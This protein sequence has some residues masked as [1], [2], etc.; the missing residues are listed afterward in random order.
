[1][2]AA[3]YIC[4]SCQQ[5]AVRDILDCG[6]QPISNRF[7]FTANAPEVT[8]P[9]ILGQCVDCGLVQISHPVPAAELR[10][11]FD[12]I[13]YTEP[14]GHLAALVSE[15]AALPGITSASR[16]GAVVFGGD[17]TNIRFKERGFENNWRV[18]LHHDLG[19]K[20]P[21]SGTETIQERLTPAV[22]QKIVNRHGLFDLL[23]VRHMVEH[24]Q[25]VKCFLAAIQTML[26][27]GGYAVF[28]VPDCERPFDELEYSILW[29]EHVF[30]FMPATFRHCLTSAGFEVLDLQRPRY[31]LVAI[32][33]KTDLVTVAVPLPAEVLAV[34]CSR[35]RKFARELPFRRA[36]VVKMLQACGKVAFF[37]AGH[38]GCMYIN[39][40]GLKS[41][42]AFVLDDHPKKQKLF[43][44]GS[45]LPILSSS[46]LADASA[47]MCLSSLG[48]DTDRK[49][50]AKNPAFLAHGGKFVSIFAREFSPNFQKP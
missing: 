13:S 6:P 1:M 32:T 22:A 11:R 34:E 2:T 39:L 23:V 9:L 27:P 21:C 47:Q 46:T 45:H 15:L 17:T 41:E 18:D 49:V 48:V 8:F 16:V 31:S 44:P 19:D 40:L 36:S 29:E 7:L 28:E 4:H 12:W 26:H 33:R 24:A 42:L 38:Q 37:G 20:E 3:A 30:Y 14:E 50:A 25:D 43:M 10:A 35:A 5:T